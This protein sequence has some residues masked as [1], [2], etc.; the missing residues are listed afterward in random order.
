L[1]DKPALARLVA[2]GVFLS[3]PAWLRIRGRE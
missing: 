2:S 3:Y 1:A